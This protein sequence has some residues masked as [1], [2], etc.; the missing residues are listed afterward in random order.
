MHSEWTFRWRE[1]FV[2]GLFGCGLM[3]GCGGDSSRTPAS[4]SDIQTRIDVSDVTWLHTDVGRW[5]V[6][7]TITNVRIRD[8]EAGGICIDHTRVN[9]WPGTQ[10]QGGT[11]FAGNPWVFGN[12]NGRWYAATYEWL[13][14][15]QTCK[16]TVA[17]SHG[18]PSRELGPHIGK[19]PLDNWVPRSGELVGFMVSTPARSGPQGPIRERSGIVVVGWP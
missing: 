5:P 9:D 12:L 17:G 6:T 13:G 18:R 2:A 7:S 15:G 14:P 3:A 10:M 1:L 16:L 11:S 8:V 4:P 19:S